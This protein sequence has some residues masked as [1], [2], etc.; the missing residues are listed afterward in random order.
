VID[1][2]LLFEQALGQRRRKRVLQ[3]E[4]PAR[5]SRYGCPYLYAECRVVHGRVLL[6]TGRWREAEDE[7]RQAAACGC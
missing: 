6:L 2:D 1:V 7:L 3:R 5:P 4:Q